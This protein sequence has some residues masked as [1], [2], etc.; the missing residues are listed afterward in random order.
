MPLF[1]LFVPYRK[2]ISPRSSQHFKKLLESQWIL[3]IF[4]FWRKKHIVQLILSCLI[5]RMIGALWIQSK[6]MDALN[7]SSNDLSRW[8]KVCLKFLNG[9]FKNSFF[10]FSYQ[11]TKKTWVAFWAVTRNISQVR[12]SILH[13]IAQRK[14]S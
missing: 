13:R 14:S 10:V 3:G 9:Y 5:A 6:S 2:W 7:T 4:S 12:W 11:Q 1:S 8:S